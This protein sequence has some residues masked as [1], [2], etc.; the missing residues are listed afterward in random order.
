MLS[1]TSQYA[2]RAMVFLAKSEPEWPIIGSRIARET[3]IPAR[4]LSSI[5][6]DLVRAGVLTATPGPTGGFRLARPAE[7]IRLIDVLL[8]FEGNV[9]GMNGCPFGNDACS[10]ESPCAGHSRWKQVKESYLR[11]LQETSVR[12]VSIRD[13]ALEAAVPS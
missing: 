6:S 5:L 1:Q 8:P 2:L 4:Y 7:C 3:Q 9:L 11:F 12:D 13:V 10:E